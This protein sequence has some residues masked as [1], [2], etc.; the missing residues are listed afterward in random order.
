MNSITVIG[1][2][3]SI[4]G[5]CTSDELIN[6]IQKISPNAI[7]CEASPEKFPAMLKATETFNPPEIKALRAIIEKQSIDVIPVDIDEDPFDGRL[8]A[9]L[10][11]FS[12]KMRDYFCASEIH[13]GEAYRL[14]FPYLNS[15]DSDQIF[16]DKS[17]MEKFFV[18]RANHHELSITYK[19]WLEWN[20]KRENH[21]IN[22]IHDYFGSSKNSTSV[23]LVGAAHRNRLMEKVSKFQRGNKLIPEWNFYPFKQMKEL[24]KLTD[25]QQAVIVHEAGHVAMAISLG[26]TPVEVELGYDGKG[27][28]KVVPDFKGSSLKDNKE[29]IKVLKAGFLAERKYT[30]QNTDHGTDDKEKISKILIEDCITNLDKEIDNDVN[31]FLETNFNTR[32]LRIAELIAYNYRNAKYLTLTAELEQAYHN[33]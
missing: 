33:S 31:Q 19:N 16:K 25:E 14:G 15:T 28:A 17:S 11:L 30:K 24:K 12:D 5:A 2:I 23:F 1:T 9:M 10:K 26:V 29:R 7:F 8:E 6:I 22:V 4:G 20:D 32:I 27:V 21:W 18:E 13:A 3:H